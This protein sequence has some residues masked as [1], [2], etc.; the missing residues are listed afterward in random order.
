MGIGLRGD[1]AEV[2]IRHVVGYRRHR[3]GSGFGYSTRHFG[4]VETFRLARPQGE[5]AETTVA[6]PHCGAAVAVE[7]QSAESARRH[8]RIL[9]AVMAV[10]AA[11]ALACVAILFSLPQEDPSEAQG[12]WNVALGTLA[13]VGGVVTAFAVAHWWQE[14]GAKVVREGAS[15]VQPERRELPAEDQFHVQE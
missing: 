3:S 2:R 9:V 8:V 10:A 12:R 1:R 5:D 7:V 14:Q 15:Y 6:C 4:P 11:A 13:A